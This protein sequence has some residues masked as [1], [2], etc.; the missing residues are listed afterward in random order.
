MLLLYGVVVRMSLLQVPVYETNGPV[1]ADSLGT[2]ACVGELYV[3]RGL[4]RSGGQNIFTMPAPLPPLPK[5]K[6]VVTS[7]FRGDN[8]W[9]ESA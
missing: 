2:P 6:K 3:D 5:K 8:S 1:R 9:V 4:V 7:V